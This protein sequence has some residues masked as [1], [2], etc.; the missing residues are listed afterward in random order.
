MKKKLSFLTIICTL[1][2]ASAFAAATDL[3]GS[4]SVST[5]KPFTDAGTTG[6]DLNLVPPE[7][8]A[9]G[10]TLYYIGTAVNVSKITTTEGY[11]YN[12][13]NGFTLDTNT[14]GSAV[15]IQDN[16]TLLTF[17]NPTTTASPT[18]A[19]IVKNSAGNYETI[20][21]SNKLVIA[22]TNPVGTRTNA[23]QVHTDLTVNAKDFQVTCNNDPQKAVTYVE[24]QGSR[25]LKI[26][27]GTF[28][29]GANALMKG[30]LASTIDLQSVSTISGTINLN[31]YLKIN[32]NTTVENGGTVLFRSASNSKNETGILFGE[33]KTITFNSGSSL[34]FGGN[35]SAANDKSHTQT[36][37]NKNVVFNGGNLQ[38]QGDWTLN[39]DAPEG[40]DES[41][42][43]INLGSLTLG[44]L[45]TSSVM[46]SGAMKVGKYNRIQA[47]N[48]VINQD[49]FYE[50]YGAIDVKEGGSITLEEGSGIL[51]QD[52]DKTISNRGRFILRSNSTVNI[53]GLSSL[54]RMDAD[55]NTMNGILLA[56]TGATTFNVKADVSFG[57][58]A[59]SSASTMTINLLNDFAT[60]KIENMEGELHEN[61][62]IVVN[63]FQN[64][65]VYFGGDTIQNYL[66]R[67][68]LQDAKGNLLNGALSINNGWLTLTAVPEPAEWAMIFGAIAL[69]LAVYRRRK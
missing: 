40:A 66:D 49:S 20:I 45:N 65:R 42:T 67:F 38:V 24:V 7:N 55:G 17:A 60:F 30:F 63:N 18:G 39:Y 61:A 58:M 51:L 15:G 16:S 6:L 2:T 43:N 14:A 62:R 29:L 41:K 3:V 64:D 33:G 59:N 5:R 27:G 11:K 1:A 54:S 50:G 26:K 13:A 10:T 22:Q 23:V 8:T 56:I 34:V 4:P 28:T 46:T 31:G 35:S 19:L 68:V 36:F 47:K 37:T 12:I 52:I 9:T 21:N 48:V 69:G 57:T 44:G 53:N 32:E 25:V